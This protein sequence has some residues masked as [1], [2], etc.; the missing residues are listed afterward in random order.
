V[1]KD[2]VLALL[3]ALPIARWE[4]HFAARPFYSVIED[5][6]GEGL[7][8][9]YENPDTEV[10]FTFSWAPFAGGH[11]TF[12]LPL[13][14]PRP[15]AL[16]GEEEV[17]AFNAR[18]GLA[19]KPGG[20]VEAWA[21]MRPAKAKGKPTLPAA[22]V[23]KVWRWNRGRHQLAASLELFVPRIWV[24]KAGTKVVTG[25][26]WVPEVASVLPAVDLVGVAHP[27]GERFFAFPKLEPLLGEGASGVDALPF[28]RV[29]EQGVPAGLQRA[30][31]KGLR[32]KPPQR[33]SFA[34]VN[35]AP[36]K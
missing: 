31:E 6:R 33:I 28:R 14:R 32:G 35:E 20:V 27:K 30:L 25:V 23:E 17:A 26:D 29:G 4:A 36:T 12:V 19:R 10:A 9:L 15:F 16:E 34:D 24:A 7:H 22:L 1:A 5:E 8:A 3:D 11:A 2:L 13:A 21:E 18:F